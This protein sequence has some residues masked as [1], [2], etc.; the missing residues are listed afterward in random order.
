MAFTHTK[1]VDI[2][3]FVKARIR[4]RN[5]IRNRIRI[6]SQTS[7]SGSDQKGPDPTESGSGSATLVGVLVFN[8]D[9]ALVDTTV[10]FIKK[11]G[12]SIGGG[13]E[14]ESAI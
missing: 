5:R 13:R 10:H 2:G 7:R 4:I 12:G 1:K 11:G 9:V 3:S 6:R 8:L 14:V